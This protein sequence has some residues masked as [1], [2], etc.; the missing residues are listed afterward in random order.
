VWKLRRK[1]EELIF[2]LNATMP[3]FLIM[4]L[5]YVFRKIGIIDLEF[6]D[7]MNRFVFL[8][9]LPVLLFKELSLSDFSAIWDLKYLI[10]CFF[11]TFLSI[12]IMCIIS[13][14]LKN[15][16]IR[17]EF[18]QA[19]FRSSA[20]LIAYAFVQNV[21][22]EAKI[23]ALMVI[24][25]VPLYN[26]ASVVIL[27][28]LSPEQGKLNRVVLKNTLKGV[29]KNPLILGILAGMIWALLKI[30]QPVIMKKSISTF[31]SAATPLGLLALGTSF[32]VKEVFSKIKIVLVSSSF[33]LL[34]LTA[35]FLP[36]AIKF[37]FKDEKLVAVLGML[38]SPTTPT[39]FTMARGMGHNGAVTSG[40]VMITTIMSIFTLTGWL[41]ILKIA[42]LV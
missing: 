19:G 41:Y 33:K 10:F 12:M 21:Y 40:T 25:A 37:G 36:I 17:R 23:V 28:L 30:P 20:A 27:M 11:A 3:V 1:M 9:L 29:M 13:L 8:A 26:V 34:I 14:F 5:G 15:K 24:G 7:K 39:S 2:C 42:G 22:G 32:D 4:V 35:I 6:A 38:G 31:A 18:I 16:S